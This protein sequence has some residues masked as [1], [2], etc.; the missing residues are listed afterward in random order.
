LEFD[1]GE[2]AA[3]EFCEGGN[4]GAGGGYDGGIGTPAAVVGTADVGGEVEGEVDG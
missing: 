2:G 4:I 1:V 3:V